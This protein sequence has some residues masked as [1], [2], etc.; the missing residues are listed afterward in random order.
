MRNVSS[1]LTAQQAYLHIG[2]SEQ[3]M[4]MNR[5][6]VLQASLATAGGLGMARWGFAN[7]HALWKP[8][9]QPR[10]IHAGFDE[11]TS[12]SRASIEKEP[13]G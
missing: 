2:F 3:N 10:R 12:E 4:A 8:P 1:R 13:L 5:R 6:K 9:P 7:P 11:F